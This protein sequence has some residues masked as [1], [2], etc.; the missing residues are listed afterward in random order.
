MLPSL[1]PSLP[2]PREQQGK[3]LEGTLKLQNRSRS[4]MYDM[5]GFSAKTGRLL[6]C[7]NLA[8][9]A[10]ATAEAFPWLTLT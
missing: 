6:M 1:T 2:P 7:D 3:Y 8:V 9:F 10:V 4:Q 5:G